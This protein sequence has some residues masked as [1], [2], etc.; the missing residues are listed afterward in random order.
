[1]IGTPSYIADYVSKK[2]NVWI[3]EPTLLAA[4]AKSQPH[5]AYTW[6]Y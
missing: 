5:S 2:V 3:E 1:M 4:I 6:P